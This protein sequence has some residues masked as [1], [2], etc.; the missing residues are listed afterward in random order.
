MEGNASA[1]PEPAGEGTEPGCAP[2]CPAG[3]HSKTR[4][5]GRKSPFHCIGHGTGAHG[6]HSPELSRS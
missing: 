2:W 1:E 6:G 4:L 5:N 3:A